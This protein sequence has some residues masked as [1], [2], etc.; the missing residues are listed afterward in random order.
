M[1]ALRMKGAP[2]GGL[3]HSDLA[4]SIEAALMDYFFDGVSPTLGQCARANI[5][6]AECELFPD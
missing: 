6:V 4:A 1:N 2:T 5:Q 3:S